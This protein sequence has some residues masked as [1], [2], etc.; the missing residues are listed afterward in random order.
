MRGAVLIVEDE[1]SIATALTYLLR[2]NNY[3]CEHVSST[4]TA[5]PKLQQGEFDLAL[6]DIVLPGGS[7]YKLC[8]QVREDPT[9]RSLKIVAMSARG[10]AMEH[11]KALAIGADAYLA[12]P[13]A[14]SALLAL[15]NDLLAI[16]GDS[17]G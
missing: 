8:R 9:L 3:C 7:G 10:G 17:R 6:I 14:S 16:R 5:L 12:K 1:T 11:R 13:F 15:L 2:H 4:E